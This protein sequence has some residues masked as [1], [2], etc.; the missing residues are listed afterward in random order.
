MKKS[1][2]SK[3]N[4]KNLRDKAKT[5]GTIII[6]VLKNSVHRPGYFSIHHLIHP[7]FSDTSI[8]HRIVIFS[9]RKHRVITVAYA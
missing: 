6:V 9:V 5:L 4:S 3:K 8:F 2:L 1:K 7:L